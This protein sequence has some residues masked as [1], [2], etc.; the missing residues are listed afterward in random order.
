MVIGGSRIDRNTKVRLTQLGDI[1]AC[2]E[3]VNAAITTDETLIAKC[4]D[5]SLYIL[6]YV[7]VTIAR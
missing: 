3:G 6:R 1:V 2:V 7:Q 4:V 5:L